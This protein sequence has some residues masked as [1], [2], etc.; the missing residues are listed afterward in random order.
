MANQKKVAHATAIAEAQE[1]IRTQYCSDASI[2]SLYGYHTNT[3]NQSQL[4]R[5]PLAN[6]L[7]LPN[8]PLFNWLQTYKGLQIHLTHTCQ[9]THYQAE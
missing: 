5:K 3:I 7:S 4:F 2:T 6:I 1:T 8:T 9:N